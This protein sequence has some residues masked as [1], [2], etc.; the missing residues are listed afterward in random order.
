[1]VCRYDDEPTLDR[2]L[3]ESGISMVA[4]GGVTMLA[5]AAMSQHPTYWILSRRLIRC[6]L[7]LAATGIVL[8]AV[9]AP[10]AK[11]WNGFQRHRNDDDDA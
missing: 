4:G 3:A 9:V 2:T 11:L 6:G 7:P 1:M 5:G 10:G 8:S